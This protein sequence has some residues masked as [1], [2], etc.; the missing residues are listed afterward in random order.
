MHKGE[1]IDYLPYSIEP[2]D[3]TPVYEEVKGWNVDLTKMTMQELREYAVLKGLAIV[4][5]YFLN[6]FQDLYL[7][8]FFLIFSRLNGFILLNGRSP[9]SGSSQFLKSP[10]SFLMVYFFKAE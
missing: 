5:H 4:Q 8:I 10:S 9:I 6:R 2:A 3:V 1:K 7:N